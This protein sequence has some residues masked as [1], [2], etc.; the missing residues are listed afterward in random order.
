[1]KGKLSV[2]LRSGTPHI[3]RAK[4]YKPPPP[5]A[6]PPSLLLLLLS[7]LGL[8]EFGQIAELED[9]GLEGKKEG[10]K[11]E[12]IVS[13]FF[14]QYPVS[15]LQGGRK[16]KTHQRPPPPPQLRQGGG[17]HATPMDQSAAGVVPQRVAEERVVRA[18][19]RVQGL[20]PLALL[21]VVVKHHRFGP[22][23]KQSAGVGTHAEEV[24]IVRV[25][26][27]LQEAILLL[28][29]DA[30]RR[31]TQHDVVE[32]VLTTQPQAVSLL[33]MWPIRLRP[34]QTKHFVWFLLL[35]VVHGG[36]D[37][38][39]GKELVLANVI[40]VC[41]VEACFTPIGQ[42]MLAS[43]EDVVVKVVFVPVSKVR[44]QVTGV[45]MKLPF[46]AIMSMIIGPAECMNSRLGEFMWEPARVRKK[47]TGGDGEQERQLIF[48][49]VLF[50]DQFEGRRRGRDEGRKGGREE[51]DGWMD[52]EEKL[53]RINQLK[54][55]MRP[56]VNELIDQQDVFASGMSPYSSNMAAAA[57]V[58]MPRPSRTLA[59][60]G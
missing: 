50:V 59:S 46:S 32:G 36:T 7:L 11:K 10:G 53:P 47:C 58:M 42:R 4:P 14:I 13:L 6:I 8:H 52:D 1:M 28:Q 55:S 37:Q 33:N 45:P 12:G 24:G 44:L 30:A 39:V 16:T 51:R 18:M 9:L 23:A 2:A 35:L 31:S 19:G 54:K 57:D 17:G 29:A 5:T 48:Q 60:N 15:Q 26:C 21:E 3:D 49:N 22:G 27:R 43:L 40:Q 41:C 38:G 25:R 34:I 20:A 56:L